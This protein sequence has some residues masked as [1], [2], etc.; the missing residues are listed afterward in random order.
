MAPGQL[1]QWIAITLTA[2]V[3]ALG[4]PPSSA[5]YIDSD[6]N[7][8]K[9]FTELGTMSWTSLA[10]IC[11]TDGTT[12][13]TGSI[14]AVD[15]TGF[16]WATPAQVRDLFAKFGVIVP[17]AGNTGALDSA[18]APAFQAAFGVTNTI[19]TFSIDSVGWTSASAMGT[20]GV[21]G[22]IWNRPPGFFD[23]AGVSTGLF[24]GS[25]APSA[26]LFARSVPEPSTWTLLGL[27]LAA[28][29]LG[30]HARRRRV[31]RVNA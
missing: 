5:T 19:G 20:L 21:I 2:L 8:W 28:V 25:T 15:I 31:A 18:W 3:L 24:M 6:G 29:W 1:K 7:E 10:L 22:E 26:F 14:G 16:I 11:P 17:V 12:A 27:C 13:C 9:T 30:A 23:V 4:A